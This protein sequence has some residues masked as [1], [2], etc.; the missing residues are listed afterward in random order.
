MGKITVIGLGPGDIRGLSVLAWDLLRSGA[1]VFLRT[2]VHPAAA[3]LSQRNIAY[4]SFDSLYESGE[5]FDDVYQSMVDRLV[6]AAQATDIVYAVPGHPMIAEQSVQLL[7]NRVKENPGIDVEIGPGQSFL[8]A[9]WGLLEIDPIDGLQLVDGLSLSASRLNPTIHTLIAQVYNPSIAAD[10]KLT[11]MEIYPDDYLVQVIRAAGVPEME[12]RIQIP[13]FELDRLAWIDHLTTVFVPA[14][15]NPA[16]IRKHPSTVVDLVRILREPG[17]C[18]WDRKQTHESLRRYVLEEA[19]EVVEAIDLGDMDA[20]AEE[21]GDL[22][23]Q[24]VLHAQIGSEIGDFSIGDVYGLLADK[25]LRRHPHVFGDQKA[26][27]PEEAEARWDAAKAM[28]RKREGMRLGGEPVRSILSS[29]KHAQPPFQYV[30]ALQEAASRVGFDWS[31]L[32]DVLAKLREETTELEAEL[33][34]NNREAARMEYGDLLFSMVNVSRW[35]EI[36]PEEALRASARK[37]TE[38]FSGVENEILAGNRG[39][40]DYTAEELDML[41]RKVKQAEHDNLFD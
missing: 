26:A 41:W 15:A 6:E 4:Q 23:L 30:L 14:S 17:G 27:S 39:W 32:H 38:R 19:Y 10:V 9:I 7:L 31:N 34:Q 40:E 5:S 18:Q 36:N 21:L 11:L 16:V 1:P 25:L 22:L 13:L 29:V 35:L 28:E 20:L 8:D 3:D 37:F 2:E 24:I 33:A 12:K